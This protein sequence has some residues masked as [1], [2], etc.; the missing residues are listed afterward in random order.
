MHWEIIQK[1]DRKKHILLY[2]DYIIPKT[3]WM[4]LNLH[5]LLEIMWQ[6]HLKFV[7]VTVVP[8]ASNVTILHFKFYLFLFHLSVL[9]AL[10]FLS[11]YIL[12]YSDTVLFSGARE[13]YFI[14]FFVCV[15]S[16]AFYAAVRKNLL[17]S[18]Y[19]HNYTW[20]VC[21]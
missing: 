11:V 21:W 8:V 16:M 12:L 3:N 19:S 5:S 10:F 15:S 20:I 7:L 13:F 17:I 2:T 18:N 1:I 9:Q 4:H 14:S 6:F